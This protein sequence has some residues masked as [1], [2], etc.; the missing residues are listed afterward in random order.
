MVGSTTN[1]RPMKTSSLLALSFSAALLVPAISFGAD[2]ASIKAPLAGTGDPDASGVAVATFKPKKSE[3]VV[4]A[5]K[6]DASKSFD[7]EIAGI[8]EGT[9]TTDKN[10]RGSVKFATPAK[11]NAAPLDFDPRAQTLRLLDGT[12]SVLEGVIAGTGEDSSLTMS[13]RAELEREDHGKAPAFA[14]FAALPKGKR[15]FRVQ[16]ANA[17]AG[18]LKV[19]VDG[20]ER[21]ELEHKGKLADAVWDNSPKGSQKLLDFDPR[22]SHIDVTSNGAVVFSGEVRAKASGVNAAAPSVSKVALTSTGADADASASAKL[23]I[24]SKARKHFSV[25]AEDLAVGTYDLLVDGVVVG[26]INVV[27]VTGG[28]KGEIEF[29]AGSDNSSELPLTFDPVGKTIAIAQGATLFFDDTFNPNVTGA[30]T[31]A[32]EPPS[33]LQEQLVSTGLDADASAKAKYEVDAK[34]RHKFSVEIED[35]D[36]GTYTLTVA[37]KVRGSI[38]AKLVNGQVKGELEFESEREPGHK[39]L[40]FD[41]RGQTIEVSSAAGVFFSH[42]LG[43][44]SGGAG[45]AAA[46]PFDLAVAL[47]SSGVDSDA[48][49]KAELKQDESGELS[50]EVQ[51]EDVATGTYDVVVDGTVRGSLT[52]ATTSKGTRGRLEFESSPKAG[53]SALNFDVAGKLVEVAQGGTV[54]FSR[55]FPTP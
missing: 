13:E 3:L 6:L 38:A 39:F 5:R 48:K 50:F 41:P 55:T 22:G 34:G 4:Q 14:T 7:V 23:R 51:V 16:V 11:K 9:L 32:A 20:I 27:A 46:T 40:D 35:V 49:A 43:S 28:T 17:P 18:T 45:G 26:A 36:A 44:G 42:V 53:Q 12:T 25:E 2:G 1:H 15:T 8:V 33:Q 52:V 37:G 24:D 54:L 21:G 47:L 29:A 19:F 30:G 31:P 10:G